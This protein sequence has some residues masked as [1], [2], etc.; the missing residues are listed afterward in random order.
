MSKYL[1]FGDT[2]PDCYLKLPLPTSVN[3]LYA[4]RKTGSRRGRV[5]TTAYKKWIKDAN[6]MLYHQKVPDKFS[7]P[8]GIVYSFELP[9]KRV[10]DDTN[11][12]KALDDYLVNNQIIE[13]DSW[14][15]KKFTCSEWLDDIQGEIVHIKIFA[16]EQ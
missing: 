15:Y 8:V 16:L 11:M 7:K 1:D 12:L 6:A 14:K 3:A 5:K 9:D 2:E 13:D 10:R 4:N